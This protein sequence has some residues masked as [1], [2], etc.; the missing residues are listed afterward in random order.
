MP[1]L[2]EVEIAARR[3]RESLAGRRIAAVRIVDPKLLANAA[4]A[5]LAAAL[6]GSVI[7]RVERRGKYLL[8]H[9]GSGPVLL[10]HLRMTGRFLFVEQAPETPGHPFRCL[11]Q[12]A[13]GGVALFRDPRRFAR[14][15]L[16]E[17]VGGAPL[18]ALGPDALVE[19][20]DAARLGQLVAG[21][22][23]SIKA[24]LMDQR[25]LAGLGNICAIEILYRAAI[26]P[27]RPA[28]ELAPGELA[29]LAE[30]FPAYLEWAIARQERRELVYLGERGA[31]NV[32]TIYRRRG[33]PGPRCGT[34]IARRVLAGRGTYFCPGCQR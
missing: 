11:F 19:P 31:E 34:A 25:R 7:D 3:L 13:E 15:E 17:D 33:E 16:R 26:A 14:F 9:A 32:F 18:A 24:L 4:P 27:D 5:A 1:E 2:P 28:G 10:V 6:E 8:L 12:L 22:R 21:R 29:S 20:P 23:Q 30:I